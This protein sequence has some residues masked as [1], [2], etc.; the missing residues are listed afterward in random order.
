MPPRRANAWMRMPGIQ[1]M[2]PHEFLGSQ[3]G[4]HPQNFL[5]KIKKIFEVMQVSGNDQDQLASYQLKDVAHIWLM[6]HAHKD[7]SEKI[8]EQAKENKKAGIANYDYSQQKSGGGN[9]RKVSRNFQPRA[10]HHLVFHPPIKFMI[11]RLGHEDLSRES[12]SSTKTYPTCLKCTRTIKVEGLSRQGQG[13]SNGRTQSTTSAPL[14]SRPTQQEY[15]RTKIVHFQLPNEPIIEWKSS[16][17]APTGRFISY[18]KARK[19]NYRG[20]IYHLVWVKDSRYETP[21]LESVPLL[22]EFPEAFLEDLTIIP[23]K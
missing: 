8:W 18:L 2:N 22:S 9:R 11:K 21:T 23:R 13:G 16:S 12:V 14:A 3:T 6:T 5:D 10:F 7:D 19:M 15:C 4:Q 17:L 1:R 20:Y